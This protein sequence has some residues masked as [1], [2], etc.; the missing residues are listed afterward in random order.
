M[1]LLCLFC[2]KAHLKT[3]FFVLETAIA[4]FSSKAGDRNTA[5]D[6]ILDVRSL[7]QDHTTQS[8][9]G[10]GSAMIQKRILK[11]ENRIELSMCQRMAI[12]ERA[13][14]DKDLIL[15]AQNQSAEREALG[16][17]IFTDIFN[18]TLGINGLQRTAKLERAALD[19]KAF[20][21]LFKADMLQ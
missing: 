14:I 4:A 8:A 1:N 11:A 15:I 16:K 3:T 6:R 13:L 17:R 19:I 10:C 18:I 21:A 20:I 5:A 12:A 9:E 2:L 7:V